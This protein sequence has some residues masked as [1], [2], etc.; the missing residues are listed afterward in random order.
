MAA[1]VKARAVTIAGFGEYVLRSFQLNGRSTVAVEFEPGGDTA[2]LFLALTRGEELA[3]VT[4]RTGT[5]AVTLRDVRITGFRQ[6]GALVTVEFAG[7]AM[8]VI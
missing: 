4:I 8:E 7:A 2:R 6:E 1:T 5:R 3:S